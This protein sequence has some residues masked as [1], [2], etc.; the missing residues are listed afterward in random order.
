LR[1]LSDTHARTVDC[2]KAYSYKH[3]WDLTQRTWHYYH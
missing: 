1:K 3:F 2:L